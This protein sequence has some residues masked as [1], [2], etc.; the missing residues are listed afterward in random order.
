MMTLTILDILYLVLIVFSAIIGTLLI[1]VLIRIYKILGP[2]VEILEIY[3]KIKSIFQ[4]YANIPE[5]IK[6]KVSETLNKKD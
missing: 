4:A 6:N 5:T 1:I 3:N 2:M